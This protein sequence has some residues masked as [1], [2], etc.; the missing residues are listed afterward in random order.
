VL[1]KQEDLVALRDCLS[2]L[3]ERDRSLIVLTAA[4]GHTNRAAAEILGWGVPDHTISRRVKSLKQ[5]LL[6]CLREKG[7]FSANSG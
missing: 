5:K 2:R 6:R 7:I 3:S 1:E 4:M